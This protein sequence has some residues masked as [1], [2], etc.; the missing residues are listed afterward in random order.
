MPLAVTR[1]AANCHDLLQLLPLALREFPRIGSRRGRPLDRPRSVTADKGYDSQPDR[2]LLTRCGIKPHIPRRR[3][4]PATPLGVVR[5]PVER[6]LIWLKQ[7]RRLRIRWDRCDTI[8]AAFFQLGCILIAR[9]FLNAEGFVLRLLL[10][11]DA[12]SS[13]AA[14]A[15][16]SG[17]RR[18]VSSPNRHVRLAWGTPDVG[19]GTL[20]CMLLRVQRRFDTR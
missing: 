17:P 18:L 1:T 15:R 13:S 8:H 3:T 19:T 14:T 7:L 20:V 16:S 9:R 2:D 6:T 10:E 5:W 4:P 12:R 11:T